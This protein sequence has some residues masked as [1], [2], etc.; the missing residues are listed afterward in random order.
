MNRTASDSISIAQDHSQFPDYLRHIPNPPKLLYCRGNVELLRGPAIAVVG[1]RKMT[2]YGGQAADAIV[3]ELV[4][5]GV[6]VVSGLALGVD[7]RAHAS[8]LDAGGATIAVLG[9][10]IDTITPFNNERLGNRILEHN[11]L[12]VSEYPGTYPADQWTFPKRNRI[13]SGIS[14]GVIVIEADRE[15]GS[16]ITARHALEQGRDVFAV[17]GN[18]FAASSAGTNHLIAQGARPVLTASDITQ[19][20]AERGLIRTRTPAQLPTLNDPVASAIFA[21]LTH[22]GPQHVDA[23]VRETKF[24]VA[25]ISGTLSLLELRGMVI[26]DG[27][28][29]WTAKK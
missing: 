6:V 27:R 23:L 25:R 26:S 28:G 20:Y 19:E 21:I 11:G 18:I 8:T 5:A 15:S 10:G 14:L 29:M 7:A 1:T 2:S 13:I 24:D 12:I 17:P 16:L 4:R 22:S 3:Q 9:S